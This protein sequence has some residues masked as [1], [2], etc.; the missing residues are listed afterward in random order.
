MTP[1]P[2]CTLSCISCAAFLVKVIARIFSAGTPDSASFRI[3]STRTAVLPLPG[4][5][6]T[7]RGPFTWFI[8]FSCSLEKEISFF[9]VCASSACFKRTIFGGLQIFSKKQP[10]QEHS[11]ACPIICCICSHTP[12]GCRSIYSPLEI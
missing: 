9:F 6:H 1:C 12:S 2:T 7:R 5:A 4:P 10:S 8:T 11:S 3:R